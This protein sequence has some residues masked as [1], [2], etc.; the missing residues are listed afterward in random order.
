MHMWLA[1][2]EIASCGVHQDV[3]SDANLERN[4]HHPL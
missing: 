2:A 1:E 3:R 4:Q